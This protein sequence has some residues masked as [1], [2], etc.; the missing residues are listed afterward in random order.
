MFLEAISDL[1]I[2]KLSDA[3]TTV[4]GGKEIIILCEKV[5]KGK[6]NIWIYCYYLP[7]KFKRTCFI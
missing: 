1:N 2:C 6:V 5:T 3:S 7:F 4:A